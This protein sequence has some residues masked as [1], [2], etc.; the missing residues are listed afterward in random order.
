MGRAAG[1]WEVN[2]IPLGSAGPGVGGGHRPPWLG[3]GAGTSLQ[4]VAWGELPRS[5][6]NIADQDFA[7]EEEQGKP[8][9][10]TDAV[11]NKCFACL[12]P[13]YPPPRC[14]WR[15]ELE[16]LFGEASAA[17]LLTMCPL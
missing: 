14:C 5:G 15:K 1:C 3:G 7:G 6:V 4:P 11:A 16:F 9:E 17:E 2:E 8:G 10:R 12:T 13:P